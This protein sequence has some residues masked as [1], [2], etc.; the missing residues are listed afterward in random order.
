MSLDSLI[1][2]F[3]N[4]GW[5]GIVAIILILVLYY[6]ISKKDKKSLSVINS[7]FASLTNTITEQNSTLI[8]AITTSNE[9]TQNRLFDLI[10]K[11]FDDKEMT[12][13]RIHHESMGKRNEIGEYIDNILFDILQKVNAQRVTLLEFHNSKENLDGLSF[14]WY[15]IQHEKQQRGIQSISAKARNLQATNLRPI[16]RRVNNDKKHIITL[17]A[18]DIENIYNESTVLYSYFKEINVEHIIYI[19]VYN[20]ETNELLGMIAIEWQTGHPYHDDLIDY[21]ELKEKAGKIEHL[22]NQARIELAE[23]RNNANNTS[24]QIKPI[25]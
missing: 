20:I 17:H 7:G 18:E 21:F 6:F 11:S 4:Y 22:Y 23:S 8:N 13:K 19:G 10:T 12:K 16:I 14:L 24:R 5:P 25:L 2:L 9:N 1:K 3:E 15:D